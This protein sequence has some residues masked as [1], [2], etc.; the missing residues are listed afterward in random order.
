[1]HRGEN[2]EKG[3]A[4]GSGKEMKRCRFPRRCNSRSGMQ[5]CKLSLN[6]GVRVLQLISGRPPSLAYPRKSHYYDPRFLSN[7]LTRYAANFIFFSFS[8]HHSGTANFLYLAEMLLK[9]EKG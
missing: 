1:M 5:P 6:K 8:F 3:R 9:R 7:T 4:A 2:E